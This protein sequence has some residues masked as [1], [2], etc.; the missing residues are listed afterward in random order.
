MIAQKSRLIELPAQKLTVNPFQMRQVFSQAELQELADSISKN[1]LIQPII[2][3]SVAD[4]SYQIVAGERRWRAC[5]IAGL[6]FIPCLLRAYSDNQ[7]AAAATV[8][9]VNRV[10]L[11]PIEEA[12]AY[13]RLVDDFSYTHDEVAAIVGKSRSKISNSLRLL[14]LENSLRQALISGDLTEGHAK[15]LLTLPLTEQLAWTDKIKQD[16]LSVRA[17]EKLLYKKN[18][19]SN[20]IAVKKDAN[21]ISLEKKISQHIGCSVNIT[22]NESATKMEINCHNLDILQGVLQ[23]M[24]CDIDDL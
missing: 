16:H 1:G 13:K 8:E 17:L 10:D 14:S 21:L 12:I 2:V 22:H 19:T 5:K 3:R 18:I 9:N 6:D 24:H 23:K 4:D 11:N 7:V 20:S 15:L